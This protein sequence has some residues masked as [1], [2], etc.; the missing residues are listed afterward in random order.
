MM[1][2]SWEGL[3]G[4]LCWFVVGIS[5]RLQLRT[6]VTDGLILD[7]TDTDLFYS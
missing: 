3:V 1:G 6:K 7:S 5:L 2:F 4:V